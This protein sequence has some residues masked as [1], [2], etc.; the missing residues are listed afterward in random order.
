MIDEMPRKSTVRGPALADEALG[1]LTLG[2]FLQ[3]VCGRY[4]TKEALA[5]RLP[6]GGPVLRRTYSEVWEEAFAVARALAARGVTKETRVGLLATNRP[7]W[8]SAV[9]GIALAGGTCVALS[10]FASASELEYQLRAADVTLLIFERTVVKRDFLAELLGICPE[11]GSASGEVHSLRLPFLRRLVC[12]GEGPAGTSDSRR[13]LPGATESWEDFL[14]A[15]TLAPPGLVEAMAAQVSPLDRGMVFFSSGSTAKPKGI[16]HAHRAAAIQ[17]WRWRRVMA[18]GD[19]VRTWAANGFFWSGNFAMALGSTLAAGGC[20]V[21]QRYFVPGEALRLMQAERVNN[22]IAWPHQWARVAEDPAWKEVDL[23]AL[24][25]VG[26]T[27]ILRTHPTVRADWDEPVAAYGNTETL[28]ISSIHPSGTPAS[29]SAGNHGRPLP[30]NTLRIVDPLTGDV[31]ARGVRG[32]I[33]VKGPTLMLSYL[34]V[35]PEDT[36]DEEGFFH[37]GDGGFIDAQG[38][39]HWEGRLNDVIK[40]GGA[41]VSPL[42]IDTVLAEYPGV[43]VA[44]TV[45]VPHDTLGEMVVACVVPEAGVTLDEAAVRSFAATRLSSYKVPRRVI[46]VAESDLTL[47]GSNKVKRNELRELAARRLSDRAV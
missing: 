16:V 17:C 40:T 18:L 31:V 39:L 36:F 19:G 45:G 32:E 1:S 6:A 22:P 9:F 24:H 23:S 42:E 5:F 3:E 33:A 15:E 12:I 2:G 11:I 8:V 30:G 34:R 27:S 14:R 28:T 10:T 25:Y 41:N 43:K 4:A 38:R 21:L 47:T 29:E 7:E 44:T 46:V 20:L 35:A 26:S 13:R 37:T